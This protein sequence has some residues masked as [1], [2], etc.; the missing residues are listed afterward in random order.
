M[1]LW[2]A[3]SGSFLSVPRALLNVQGHPFHSPLWP[4]QLSTPAVAAYSGLPWQ[5]RWAILA[6]LALSHSLSLSLILS[7]AGKHDTMDSSSTN[8]R[9]T[10]KI[11][12]PGRDTHHIFP[13]DILVFANARSG[14]VGR[15]LFK[16]KSTEFP[17]LCYSGTLHC[18]FKGCLKHNFGNMV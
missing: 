16:V 12:I 1:L 15:Y 18:V 9:A 11:N 5:T 8:F 7:D 17:L 4:F 3:P 10:E 6:L 13:T 2:A 14:L